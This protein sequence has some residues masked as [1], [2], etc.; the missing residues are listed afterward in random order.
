MADSAC[1]ST[2][3][4]GGVKGNLG[5]IGVNGFV[6]RADCQAMSNSS[7]HINSI[8]YYSQLRGKRTGLVTTA[9]V[10]HASPA[11]VYAH[12]AERDWE[13]DS[14]V[15]EAGQ[16]PAMCPDIARQL[17]H[18]RTGQNLNV[19]LGGGRAEFLPKNQNGYRSD[20][21]DLIYEWLQ[22]KENNNFDAEYVWNKEQ[23]LNVKSS[24]DYLLGSSSNQNYSNNNYVIVY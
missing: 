16:D 1:S 5:T 18:G 19:I 23:L 24:T 8:A 12:T 21:K 9:R 4:L 10:T 14:N 15:L 22:Q 17:I 20:D 7:N 3:Y 6:S 2:A 11:G 13:S